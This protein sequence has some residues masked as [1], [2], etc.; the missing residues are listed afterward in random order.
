MNDFGQDFGCYVFISIP[1]S[2]PISFSN[3]FQFHILTQFQ[4][5]IELMRTHEMQVDLVTYG[6]LS[7]SCKTANDASQFFDEIDIRHTAYVKM[8][9][10]II[11]YIH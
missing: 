8:R 4:E 9:Q 6:L 2:I 11:I 10:Y 1:I 3:L 5:V 7:M